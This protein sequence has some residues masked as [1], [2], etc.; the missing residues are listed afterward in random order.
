[1]DTSNPSKTS[2]SLQ[3]GSYGQNTDFIQHQN[4]SSLSTFNEEMI[5]DM[6]QNVNDTLNHVT[7]GGPDPPQNIA[8]VSEDDGSGTEDMYIDNLENTKSPDVDTTT[9]TTNE[10]H[11][12]V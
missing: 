3:N 8:N 4:V 1:M 7:M 2:I 10:D 11:G 5:V 12:D 6:A 9:K